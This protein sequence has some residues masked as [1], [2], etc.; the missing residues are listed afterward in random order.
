MKIVSVRIQGFRAIADLNVD[1]DDLTAFVGTGGVGKTRLALQVATDLL[2]EF[3]DGVSFVLLAPI[4][5][6]GCSIP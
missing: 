6:V 1:F 5:F 4:S 3:A 2:D